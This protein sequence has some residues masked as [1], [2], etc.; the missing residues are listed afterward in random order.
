MSFL[1][2]SSVHLT[3]EIEQVYWWWRWCTSMATLPQSLNVLWT[4]ALYVCVIKLTWMLAIIFIH[5]IQEKAEMLLYFY[6]GFTDRKRYPFS[7][8]STSFLKQAR[9]NQRKITAFVMQV[10]HLLHCSHRSAYFICM[11]NNNA[12]AP[13]LQCP[14][15][16]PRLQTSCFE[17]P[18]NRRVFEDP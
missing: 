7:C 6:F 17:L 1:I 8:D 15:Y 9:W 2:T 13:W 3:T 10:K 18:S 11:L 12:S 4:G 5:R 16:Q 14:S